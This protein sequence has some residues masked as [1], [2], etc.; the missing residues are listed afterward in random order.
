MHYKPLV[1]RKLRR[2]RQQL[3]SIAPAFAVLTLLTACASP[4]LR[5][6]TANNTEV[7]P[8]ITDTNNETPSVKRDYPVRPFATQTFYDLLVAEIAGTRGNL[9]LALENYQ[10]Q[11][12]ATRDPGVVAR[13]VSTASYQKNNAALQ[14]LG[15]LW[16]EVE[17]ENLQARNMAFYAQAQRGN[18]KLAFAHADYLLGQNNGK[19]MVLLP[20]YTTKLDN[21]QRLI[22]LE[23]YQA[24][25]KKHSGKRDFLLGKALILTQLSRH[26][27]ALSAVRSILNRQ[28]SDQPA[29]LV[30]AQ[31]LHRAERPDEAIAELQQGLKHSPKSQQLQLQLIRF[32]AKNDLPLAI[33][34][35]TALAL[36]EDDNDKFK[37]ALALLH[38]ENLDTEAA[39]QIYHS[40]IDKG[41]MASQAHYQLAQMAEQRSLLDDALQH[42]LQVSDKALLLQAT[43]RISQILASRGQL[44]DA[45]LHLHQLRLDHPDHASSFYQLESQLLIARQ[46]HQSA[47][48]LLDEG[49]AE[50][51]DNIELLYSRSLVHEKLGNIAAT[52]KDLRAIIK[53]D[54]D[55]ASALNALG[56]TLA[57]RTERYDEALELI[58]RAIAIKPNDPAIQDSLGWVLFKRGEYDKALGHLR[59]AMH[60]MPDPEVA[61]HLGEVLWTTGAEDEARSVWKNAINNNPSNEPL[62]NT[63]KRLDV[64]L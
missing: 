6:S 43:S 17:P 50:H 11:A 44:D 64:Q 3:K 20:S 53:Q 22:L 18:F 15:V 46:G 52:E 16:A 35:M 32:V 38:R 36:Q 28:A 54:T 48:T 14:E 26:D 40:L 56:Y 19:Y 21:E 41:H 33:E 39:R 10:R 47:Q 5:Q 34:K 59:A 29:R 31:I 23:Q 7:T 9:D 58:Q 13:A 62:L 27:E 57:T 8:S 61:A 25:D 12:L 45:R 42:Y 1:T 55:N 51:P 37:L 2:L 30:A 4:E 24:S 63:L 60:T 49:L